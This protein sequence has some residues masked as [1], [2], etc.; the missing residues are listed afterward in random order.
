MCVCVQVLQ[1]SPSWESQVPKEMMVSQDPQGSPELWDSQVKLDHPV[2]V[3][4]AEAATELP[5]KQ[6]SYQ[7]R[8]A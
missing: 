7:E 8:L 2:C 3:T 4:A 6:V 5:S 1:V